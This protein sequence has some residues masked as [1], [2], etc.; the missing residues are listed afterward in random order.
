MTRRN[1]MA[2]NIAHKTGR[3]AFDLLP[4]RVH[5]TKDANI[6]LKTITT[7]LLS[8]KLKWF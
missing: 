4:I 1:V 5:I 7:I 6:M 2:V 8:V 3:H